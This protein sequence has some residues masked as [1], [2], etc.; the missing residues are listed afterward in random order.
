MR[1]VNS[2]K[3]TLFLV[4]AICTLIIN[5]TMV[6]IAQPGPSG[7]I[8]YDFLP[9]QDFDEPIVLDDSTSIDNAQVQLSKLR[10]T[11]TYPVVFS[12]GRTVLVNDLSYQLI[13]FEYR[14]LVDP[15]ER[16]HS[17]SYTLMLQ[18]RLS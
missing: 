2:I 8:S 1:R 3:T 15:L 7:S 5:T 16:L 4:V 13:E 6:A 9:Y 10:A 11:V 17:A 18:H 12:E 14:R